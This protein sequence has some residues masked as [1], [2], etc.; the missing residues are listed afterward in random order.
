MKI[1]TAF[2]YIIAGIMVADGKG[3]LVPSR[4]RPEVVNPDAPAHRTFLRVARRCWT[5]PGDDASLPS[6]SGIGTSCT[7]GGCHDIPATPLVQPTP[8]TSE[9]PFAGHLQVV[10]AFDER[11]AGAELEQEGAEVVEQAVLEV[12]LDR[13]LTECTKVEEVRVLQR[14]PGKVGLR[15]RERGGEV[16]DGPAHDQHRPADRRRENRGE[17]CSVR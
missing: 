2:E 3:T 5:G 1:A 16:H 11:E 14:R 7:R 4:A 15:R 12:P 13:V 6:R 8:P 17:A 9:L 10:L